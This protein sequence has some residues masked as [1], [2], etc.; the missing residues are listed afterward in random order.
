VEEFITP[1]LE[2]DNQGLLYEITENGANL[3]SGER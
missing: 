2:K 1:L 3:S